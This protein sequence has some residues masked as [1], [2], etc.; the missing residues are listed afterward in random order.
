MQKKIIRR[1]AESMSFDTTTMHPLLQR[2]YAIRGVQSQT[3]LERGLE[4]LLPFHQL[5]QIDQAVK[6]LADTL[7]KQEKILIVGDFDA[8]GATSTAVAVR[9]LRS[10]GAK[11]VEFLVPN[12]FAYGYG[13]TPELVE[14]AKTFSPAL[15]VTVDNGIANNVGVAAAK[16]YGMKVLVTDHHLPGPTLPNADVIVN[17]NQPL[18]TFP[19]KNLA[20]VGVIFYVMLAL[21][22]HLS[23]SGWFAEQN[24][25]EPNMSKLLDL[26]A[27]GTVADVVP[28]DHNNRILVHQGLRRIRASQCVPGIT[29]LLEIAGRN[30][31]RLVA[32][33]LGFAV[34]PRLNAAGRLDDMS[35]G[36]ECLLCD[37]MNKAREMAAILSQMNDE[38]RT[39]EQDM[40]TQALEKLSDF[41]P[42][43]KEQ[44]PKGICLFDEQ[45]HQGVIGIVASRIK[46]RF[47]RPVIAFALSN[48][49]ELKGSARSVPGLH[50]RDVLAE[51]AAAH[52]HL[53]EKFGGHAMAAGLSLPRASFHEFSQAFNDVVSKHLTDEQMHNCLLSDGELGQHE[54]TLD[55]A[56]VLREAGPWGQSFPEP[57]FD[58]VFQLLDQRVVGN[59]HLK[60]TLAKGEQTIDAIAFNVDMNH[61]P[62][63]RC[64]KVH[65]AFRMDVNEFRGIRRVQLIV[66]HL[67]SP[68]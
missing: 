57:L 49:N 43:K 25:P 47:H 60:M 8:D 37:D 66:E 55:I 44:L 26:V 62:N 31:A 45:W 2:I 4:Q 68:T 3:E 41:R 61:W 36:I 34:A 42:D 53:I 10:F 35:F 33:D 20:G 15:I 23:E 14:V 63:Y 5:L 54:L 6:C 52:P 59:K 40:Q 21:R 24:I 56:E 67:E 38:R 1:N 18:D 50:I 7:Q 64:E 29:A 58:G 30:Q 32:G 39:I 12:R 65:L 28:L 9:A 27:L 22:R 19:S 13:L 11:H 51:I 48:E 46:D 17:P 16:A